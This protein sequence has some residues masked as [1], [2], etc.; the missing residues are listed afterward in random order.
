MNTK[1]ILIAGGLIL[2]IAT[3]LTDARLAPV[4]GAAA[5]IAVIIYAWAANRSDEEAD[6]SDA[7]RATARQKRQHTGPRS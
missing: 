4:V 1:A 3:L 2:F 5:L 6:F 7:E